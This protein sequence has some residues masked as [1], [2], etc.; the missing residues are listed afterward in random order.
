M[1]FNVRTRSV[2]SPKNGCAYL[3]KNS[4][5]DWGKYE[6][7][8]ELLICINDELRTIGQ[9]KIG[10]KGLKPAKRNERVECSRTPNLP[11]QFDRLSEDFFSLGQSKTY[12]EELCALP[13]NIKDEIAQG[14]CDCAYNL[15][16]LYKF[17]DEEV[18]NESLLRDIFFM[19]VKDKLS[20]IVHG[21]AVLT[22]FDFSCTLDGS[23]DGA[24][25]T[26]HVDPE[27]VIPTN[28]HVLIGSNG[29]GKTRFMNKIAILESNEPLNTGKFD[30]RKS[31]FSAVIHAT[32][33]VFD[34]GQINISGKSRLH[35]IGLVGYKTG[36]DKENNKKIYIKDKKVLA[37]DF[38]ES[39][40]V[41]SAGGRKER[42]IKALEFF[43]Y[44]TSLDIEYF[45]K[46]IE[47][48]KNFDKNALIDKFLEMSS[49]HSIC[50]LIITQLVRYVEEKTLVLLDEP[51]SHLHPP[52]LSAF[53]RSL[54]FL[55][56]KRN[57]VAL[58]STHS[59]VVLQEVP[60]NCVWRIRR[61]GNSS[62]A[63]RLA[64]ETFGENIGTLTREVFGLEI[65]NVGYYKLIEETVDE[66]ST[67]TYEELFEHL[68]GSLG[69]EASAILTYFYSQKRCE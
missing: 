67:K 42:F 3:I 59:P 47:K 52:L 26:F 14:L 2:S 36:I 66:N 8:Y 5:D 58:L 51:E 7:V 16:L 49:G 31:I 41:C 19:D 44:D 22:E 40:S 29:V 69:T 20:K 10:Q 35:H 6:T 62:K 25:V 15:Q 65:N 56:K 39:F 53:I 9:V 68:G 48:D 12:Y 57:A 27:S 13:G 18:M 64:C 11:A 28:I 21:D 34:A 23:V 45:L 24:E 46:I 43:K 1:L 17:K 32:F 38:V 60:L 61:S 55:L 4:W 50:I 33:S 30:W 37:K 63:E 54:S